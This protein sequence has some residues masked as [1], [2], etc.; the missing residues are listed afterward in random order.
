MYKTKDIF[1]LNQRVCFDLWRLLEINQLP[2]T[3]SP[4]L[5]FPEKRD[6][7]IRISEQESRILYC[8]HLNT[9]QYYYSI[10]TPTQNTYQQ[11]GTSPIS[12]S[13]DLSLYLH[14]NRTFTKM[15]NIEFKALN[16]PEENIRKDIEKLV[17]EKIA[18]NWF[19]TLKNIDSGTL[20]SLFK[21][22][23]KALKSCSPLLS[24]PAEGWY[25]DISIIF[26][27]CVLDKRLAFTKQFFYQSALQSQISFDQ[28]VEDFFK[29]DYS[30]TKEDITVTESN[31]WNIY[32]P[33]KF[34]IPETI[35]YKV[36]FFEKNENYIKKMEL[37]EEILG[38]FSTLSQALPEI[39]KN[40]KG[41]YLQVTYPDSRKAM[42]HESRNDV[43]Y[44]AISMTLANDKTEY[45]LHIGKENGPYENKYIRIQ[46]IKE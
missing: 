2:S 45:D 7:T 22:C 14:N 13:T 37:K 11:T 42:V 43:I 16:V 35:S 30:A 29:L 21:K 41:Q 40:F 5:I 4:R 44:E 1:E 20:P 6:E 23:I 34:D 38:I 9:T 28:Y 25:N 33:Q 3:L 15:V 46:K 19:H 8:N 31:G 18:G 32:L 10:E 24:K 36:S 27:F 39:L 12:A 17:K 26:C